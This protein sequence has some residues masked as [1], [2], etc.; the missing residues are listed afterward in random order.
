MKKAL[1]RNMYVGQEILYVGNLEHYPTMTNILSVIEVDRAA[2]GSFGVDI[3]DGDHKWFSMGHYLTREEVFVDYESLSDE[4]KF[5]IKL[6]GAE[7]LLKGLD[8]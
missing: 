4:E 6:G 8:E 7:A 1:R 3:G 2:D 5:L